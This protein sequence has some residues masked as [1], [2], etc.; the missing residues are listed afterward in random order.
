MKKK[1][2][3]GIDYGTLSG[4]A[5]LVEVDT[6]VEVATAVKQYT[7]QVMDNYLCDGVTK[8]G[9]DW[10]LQHPADYLDVL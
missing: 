7:H 9:T 4:R 5:V 10:A 8:L 1:Y 3:I 6:G 2:S